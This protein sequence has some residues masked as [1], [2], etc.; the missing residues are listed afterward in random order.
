MFSGGT[1]V[2]QWLK[3][4]LM[5]IIMARLRMFVMKYPWTVS[6]VTGLTDSLTQRCE[7]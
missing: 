4:G 1:E 3:R 7:Y 5:K 2:E 6:C